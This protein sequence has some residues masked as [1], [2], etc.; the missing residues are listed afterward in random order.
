MLFAWNEILWFLTYDHLPTPPLAFRPFSPYRLLAFSASPL[1]ELDRNPLAVMLFLILGGGGYL[2]YATGS[3][4]VVRPIVMPYVTL[5]L[6]F[7]NQ[8]GNTS[9]LPS[10]ARAGL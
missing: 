5:V 9:I 8:F 3:W 1:T 2:I 4:R 10:H 7:L 6:G